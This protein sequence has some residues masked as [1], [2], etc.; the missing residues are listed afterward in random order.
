[1]E[2]NYT[3]S[4]NTGDTHSNVSVLNAEEHQ[5]Y[6]LGY[7]LLS[8]QFGEIS[9]PSIEKALMALGNAEFSGPGN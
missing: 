7:F 8:S 2:L 3:F 1:M 6:V 4:S 5:R 9:Q